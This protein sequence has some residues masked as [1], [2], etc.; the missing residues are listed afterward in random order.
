MN[1]C[2]GEEDCLYLSVYD[3][4]DNDDDVDVDNDDENDVHDDHEDICPGEEDCL[5][6]SV[7]V[8]HTAPAADSLPVM[9]WI[10][11]GS[12]TSGTGAS[13]VYC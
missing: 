13:Q 3:N 8:P 12:F 5:Y 2:P 11:G 6:L 10:Y 1:I 4:D 9:V 7:Y